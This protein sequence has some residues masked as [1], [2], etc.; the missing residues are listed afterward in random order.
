[1]TLEFMP[2]LVSV[3]TPFPY[4]IE[5]KASIDEAKELMAQHNISHLVVTKGDDPYS[6]ISDHEFQHHA[7][8]Y[9]NPET[10]E[11][12]VNDICAENI[13]CA[14]IHDPLDKVL[15]AMTQQH[16]SSVVVLR[17]GELVGIFTTTDACHHFA[18]FLQQQCPGEISNIIA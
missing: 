15:L 18:R 5:G 9:G 17:E 7:A 14:D 13:V 1:M 10:S 12:T 6:L 2:T 11:L 16:L 4:H 3:L 8:L